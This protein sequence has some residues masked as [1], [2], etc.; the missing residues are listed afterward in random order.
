MGVFLGVLGLM[1]LAALLLL[2]LWLWLDA[3]RTVRRLDR[4]LST[5]I[6]GGFGEESF[7]ESAPSALESRMARF[8][9]GSARSLRGVQR[10]RE[11][12]QRLL[13]DISH[14][15]KTPLANLKLYSSLLM[16]EELTP[17]QRE[18]AQV[19][20]QQSEKLSFLIETLVKLSRLETDVLAVTPKSQ[21]LSPLLERAASQAKAAAEHPASMLAVMKLDN[22]KIEEICK[23]FKQVYPV[24]YNAPGQL[25]VAGAIEEMDAFK[26]AVREAGG[27]GLPVAVGGGF[28]SPFMDGASREFSE[29][30]REFELRKPA[31]TVYSN[32]TTEPYTEN[33]LELMENQINHSL[34][35]QESMERMA[36][37]GFDTFIEVGIGDTLK[38][39]IKRILPEARVYSVSN[40]EEI[41]KVKEE[42]GC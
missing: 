41:E 9:N 32:F 11:S 4:M 3:R 8:L 2:G 25:V 26:Q 6:D 13:S 18:Q 20:L 21:P 37:D 19:I 22:A 1:A 23:Q 38:K 24:N 29:E 5:A 40:M 42:M 36:A 7:D 33:V 34:R 35:W 28:H 39:L 10:Q 27:R 12:I 30:A 31:L 16:E 14:Q 17:Q 15:T